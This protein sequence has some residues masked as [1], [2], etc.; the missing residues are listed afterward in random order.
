MALSL[1][2]GFPDLD[3][4]I[5]SSNVSNNVVDLNRPLS[6]LQFIKSIKTINEPENIQ[7]S[8]NVYLRK[9]N[10]AKGNKPQNDKSLIIEKYRE[11][12]K[13]VSI[14]YTTLEEKK[15]LKNI[16]FSDPLDLDVAIGFYSRKLK[17]IAQ[18]YNSKRENLKF[19]LV[20]KKMKGTNIGVEKNIKELILSSLAK[21]DDHKIIMD[22]EGITRKIEVEIDELYD[23]SVYFNQIPSDKYDN[24]DLDYGEDIFLRSDTDLIEEIFKDVSQTIR[25]LKEVET[26][27]DTKRRLTNKY[28]ST[29]YYYLSTGDTTSEFLSGKILEADRPSANFLNPKFPTSASTESIENLKTIR[30]KGYFRPTN[31]SIVTLDGKNSSFSFKIENLKPN[32]IYYFPDPEITGFNGDIMTFI[33]DDSFLKKNFTSGENVNQPKSSE[34]DTKYYGYKSD[35][36]PR[37]RKNLD[38]L[39]DVG[40]IDDAKKD[41]YG[42]LFGLV[43]DGD[44]FKRSIQLEQEKKIKNLL[45]DGHTFYDELY[46]EGYSFDYSTVDNTT[47]KETIRS[48]LTANTNGFDGLLSY[49]TLFFR[50]FKPYEEL[51]EKSDIDKQYT[52]CDGGFFLNQS[53]VAYD[54]TVSSDLNSFDTTG[55]H[56]F[57]K[58]YEGALHTTSP[59]QRALL[60]PSAPTL[61]AD[62][63][64]SIRPDGVITFL[65]DGGYFDTP[66]NFDFTFPKIEYQFVPQVEKYSEYSTDSTQTDFYISRND[67]L[68]TI[69][70]KNHKTKQVTSI[71]EALSY[72]VKPLYILNEQGVELETEDNNFIFLEEAVTKDIEENT[73]RFEIVHDL[74]FI[75]TTNYLIITRINY[76]SGV[77]EEPSTPT[78]TIVKDTSSFSKLSNRFKVRN[79]VYYASTDSLGSG[80]NFLIY[81]NIYEYDLVNYTNRKIFPINL[82]DINNNTSF[83]NISG[84]D[85][86]YLKCDDPILTY[87]SK[88]NIFNIS[89]L[90]KDQNDLFYLHEYDFIIDG[91]VNFTDHSRYV[92]TYDQYSN[93]FNIDYSTLNVF[94]SSNPVTIESGYLVI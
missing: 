49:Y 62:M 32:T 82:G 81:P 59:L 34:K 43:K 52:I 12:L 90:L 73:K 22:L 47:F 37:E 85:V 16:D 6:F 54:D 65:K 58:L 64:K 79:K 27:F 1:K 15:F 3:N 67:L 26:L 57:S 7:D 92:P 20:R 68:G 38:S 44:N 39:F 18:S 76:N 71:L 60:D 78:V 19:E 24:K 36:E 9:W 48:G 33:V 30:D 69:Y 4:S 51:I 77:F 17:E 46:G 80:K 56:Y 10:N 88:N 5:T 31:T 40:Y 61:V 28:I 25:D 29:D 89:M 63:T 21:L 8:Y 66:F 91:T 45:L 86:H 23:T 83:F 41:I 2:F 42:N 53:N 72:L 94:M 75:E 11:F 50:H 93:L 14:N 70:V 35:I 55:L 87:S 74:L 13:E 84:G